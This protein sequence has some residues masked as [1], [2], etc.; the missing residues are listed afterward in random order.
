MTELVMRIEYADSTLFLQPS[1]GVGNETKRIISSFRQAANQIHGESMVIGNWAD[2]GAILRK[3]ISDPTLLRNALLFADAMPYW[4]PCPAID[5]YEDE[6]EV[7]FEWFND[8]YKIVNA[9]VN[10]D[11]D[12]Y[13]S[14]LLGK[15]IRRSGKDVVVHGIPQSLISA[16][17]KISTVS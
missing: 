15:K 8:N 13:Y 3:E 5:I 9:V 10:A 16:I 6:L 4:V 14:G 17:Q 11:G 2:A 7:V 1:A 12:L